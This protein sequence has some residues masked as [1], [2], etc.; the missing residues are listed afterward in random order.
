MRCEQIGADP[1][2]GRV[3]IRLHHQGSGILIHAEFHP[4]FSTGPTPITVLQSSCSPEEAERL[5]REW[6]EP[7]MEN[8]RRKALKYLKKSMTSGER[9]TS[10]T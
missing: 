1:L 8:M 3:G 5:V 6:L 9:K 4:M 7:H 10:A 2:T